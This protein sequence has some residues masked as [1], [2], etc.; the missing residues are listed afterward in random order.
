MSAI[1]IE[2]AKGALEQY[3]ALVWQP[4]DL[5]ELRCFRGKGEF[6][7]KWRE[8]IPAGEIGEWAAK[9]HRMNMDGWDV[10]AGVNPRSGRGGKD[11]DVACARTLFADFDGVS[12]QFVRGQ[13]Q[14]SEAQPPTML[15]E[16][17][18]GVHAYWV[19]DEAEEDL[20]RWCEFMRG[21]IASL[22]SDRKVKDPARIMRLP[23]FFNCKT[24]P[25]PVCKIAEVSADEQYS[26]DDIG[27][28]AIPKPKPA[29]WTGELKLGDDAEPH[30][31][32]LQF[33][34][35]GVREGDRNARL[36]E[37][38][39]DLSGRGYNHDEARDL[40]AGPATSLGLSP[41]EI[42]RTIES[43]FSEPRT[44]AGL[45]AGSVPS[46][47]DVAEHLDWIVERSVRGT[48]ADHEEAAEKE[49]E[50][51]PYIFNAIRVEQAVAKKDGSMGTK[52]VYAAVPAD[53]IAGA[54]R[55]T[56]GGWPKSIGGMLVTLNKR[57]GADGLPTASSLRWMNTHSKLTAWIHGVCSLFMHNGQCIDLETR[58]GTTP[59]TRQELYDAL[60]ETDADGFAFRSVELL[61]HEPKVP[62]VC[63]VECNLPNPTGAAL[64]EFLDRMNPATEMDCQKI[65][66]MLGTCFWGGDAGS[67]P[68]FIIASDDGR[69]AGKTT[70]AQA[71]GD[72]AGGA[73]GFFEGEDPDTFRQRLL[74]DSALSS[75]VVVLDNLKSV[76]SSGWLEA[77]VTSPCIEGKKMFFGQMS[78]PNHMTWIVTANVPTFSADLASRAVVI[79]LGKPQYGGGFD[80]WLATFMRTRRAE[81][82]ADVLDWLRSPVASE[83]PVPEQDRFGRWQR[84]ILQRLPDGRAIAA[85]VKAQRSELDSEADQAD[86]VARLFEVLIEIG[87]G[88]GLGPADGVTYQLSPHV[89]HEA[90][91]MA[92]MMAGAVTQRKASAWIQ[93]LLDRPAL[94]GRLVRHKTNRQRL[95]RFRTDGQ[96]AIE[97]EGVEAV[98]PVL[99]RAS[100]MSLLHHHEGTGSDTSL[101]DGIPI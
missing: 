94:R 84:A 28:D 13:L 85:D 76:L 47:D 35:G 93:R 83:I 92:G 49:R 26:I 61:P 64:R 24:E 25:M 31:R 15:I 100:L 1:T 36:Y 45:G 20:E 66:A 90:V 10:Y 41:N 46:I 86:E 59:V 7:D 78:K 30:P 54:I 22:A 6:A 68:M 57:R 80:E 55:D 96:P 34:Y 79:K 70:L 101:I 9:L 99:D 71:V 42:E 98:H 2:S 40:L 65:K 91:Q 89:V 17:G 19:L 8:W 44:P 51:R 73:I 32:T 33:V 5:I 12:L 75:R 38:A 23:G 81:L 18:H 69:G 56:F 27:F 43:A 60:A 82:I 3:A 87:R 58:E 67:R 52:Q 72:I 95:W 63:Y 39:C 77:M 53:Q 14:R 4:E 62:G 97:G 16:S 37:A 11:G 74:S 48:E 50:R 21:V 29:I 88:G